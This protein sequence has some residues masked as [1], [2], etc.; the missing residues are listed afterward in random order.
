MIAFIDAGVKR[1]SERFAAELDRQVAAVSWGVSIAFDSKGKSARKWQ[2]LRARS[3]R[4]DS[5]A[6]SG[7][8]LE[9]AVMGIAAVQPSLVKVTTAAE[10][11]GA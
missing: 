11:A 2:S 1:Q 6:L 7:A 8:A 4:G 3:G 9:T 5:G 10:A